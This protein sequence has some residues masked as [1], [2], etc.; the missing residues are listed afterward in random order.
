MLVNS[1]RFD[2]RLSVA[3]F[4][5]QAK[6]ICRVNDS[7]FLRIRDNASLP[8]RSSSLNDRIPRADI[9]PPCAEKL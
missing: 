7:F 2:Q 9:S 5:L 8:I 6:K 4:F 1:Q 3:I